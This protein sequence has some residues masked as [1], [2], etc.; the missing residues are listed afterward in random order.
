LSTDLQHL[1]KYELRQRLA[2]NSMAE[3]WKSYDSQLKRSVAMKFLR[4][5]LQTDPDFA[6]RFVREAEIIASL[7]HPNIVRIHDY[8]LLLPQTPGTAMAYLVM[9]W[10]EGQTLAEYIR[11]APRIGKVSPGADILQ[12]LTSI[13]LAIDYAHRSGIIHGN[14][15]PTNIFLHGYSTSPNWIGEPLVTH[16]GLAGLRGASAATLAHRSLESALYMSSEQTQG[17]AGN[18]RSDIYSLGVILYEMCTGVLP[19]QGNRPIA[20]MMQHLSAPPTPPSNIN[21]SIS[22]ALSSVILRCLAKDP[23]VRFPSASTMTAALAKALDM[24]VPEQLDGLADL[25]DME[26]RSSPVDTLQTASSLPSISSSSSSPT[27]WRR[28][29]GA[30]SNAGFHASP[31]AGAGQDGHSPAALSYPLRHKRRRSAFLSFALVTLLLVT[32]VGSGLAAL[33]S[34][35]PRSVAPTNA[36]VGHAFF[37]SSGQLNGTSNQGIIDELQVDLHNLAE[38]ASGKSYYAWL[39]ADKNQSEVPAIFLGKLSSDHGNVRF[40][41]QGD[42]QH[43]NLLKFT[44][45]FLI[46]EEDADVTPSNPSPDSSTW[47]YYAEIPQT[48]IPGDKL[49]FSMLDHFRHLL[50]ESPELSVRGLHGGMAIWLLENARRV[51]ECANSAKDAWARS[52]A[53]STHSQLTCVLD[54]LDGTA[55]VHTDVPA[56]H[57]LA[58]EAHNAQVALLGSA[59]HDTDPPG[60]VYNEEVPPGYV[61]LIGLHLN[62]AVLSPQA[63]SDQRTLAGQIDAAMNKLKDVFRQVHQDAK[64]LVQMTDRQLLQSS[65][66]SILNDLVMQAQNAYAGQLDPTTGASQGGAVWIYGNIERL[67]TFDVMQFASPSR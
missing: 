57:P 39:L 56:I 22:P 19:F 24:A 36:I 45:R 26:N 55:F 47:H 38:P 16:F 12:L 42:Q 9:D 67:V 29:S 10:I 28:T 49:H 18:E 59:P 37:V 40:L 53:A 25:T 8:G 27:N 35:A 65:S 34:L 21:P 23:Q 6:T 58:A 41:Y 44:S 30:P 63:T 5:N 3:V 11:S 48:P 32:L 15:K 51:L 20:L 62:G 66:L 13:S 64:L 50:V 1:G 7:H 43:T 17:H 54:Y 60:Y 52:D 33:L 61:Y 4:A 2:H 14:L 31:S 46:T